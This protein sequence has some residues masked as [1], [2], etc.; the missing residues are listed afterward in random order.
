MN[1]EI[2]ELNLDE[3]NAV[4]G[5]G[6]RTDFSFSIGGLIDVSFT[7]D[8]TCHAVGISVNG[9]PTNVSGGCTPL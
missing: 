3:L 4:S 7:G 8:S 9:G 5:G 1:G 2:L 6:K